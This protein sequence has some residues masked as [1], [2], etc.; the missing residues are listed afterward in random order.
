MAGRQFRPRLPSGSG[1]VAADVAV[2]LCLLPLPRLLCDQL[3]P[4]VRLF[5][6]APVAGDRRLQYM[7]NEAGRAR[8][9]PAAQMPAAG[10]TFPGKASRPLT[11]AQNLISY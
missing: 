7:P 3:R 1:Y 5:R 4:A 11:Q 9:S 2:F 6:L 8:N 10:T